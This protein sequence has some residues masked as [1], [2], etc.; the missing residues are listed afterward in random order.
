MKWTPAG[1]LSNFMWAI[2]ARRRAKTANLIF[3]LA[4]L[5]ISLAYCC[6]TVGILT[7]QVNSGHRLLAVI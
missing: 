4:G 7:E 6:V 3:T 5:S 1:E 2:L